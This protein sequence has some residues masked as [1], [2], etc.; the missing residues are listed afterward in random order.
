[1]RKLAMKHAQE[2][3]PSRDHSATFEA[4]E[5]GSLCGVTPPP[6]GN[7]VAAHYP[8]PAGALHVAAAPADRHGRVADGIFEV[9]NGLEAD[10]PRILVNVEQVV[11]VATVERESNIVGTIVVCQ[12]RRDNH[13]RH[14]F[15]HRG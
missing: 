8:L 1:M 6:P 15:V 10:R 4:L 9:R 14:T 12:S 13:T 2:M 5:L 11:V 7:S 3:Q